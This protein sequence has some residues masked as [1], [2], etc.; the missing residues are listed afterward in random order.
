M[1]TGRRT[2]SDACDDLSLAAFK[3]LI[4]PFPLLVQHPKEISAMASTIT[5]TRTMRAI[6]EKTRRE[7]SFDSNISLNPVKQ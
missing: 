3:A 7:G 2:V 1:S 6:P 4:L 5:Q